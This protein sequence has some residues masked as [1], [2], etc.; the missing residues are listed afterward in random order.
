MRW[1]GRQDVEALVALGPQEVPAPLQMPDQRMRL[2]LGRDADAADT[3]VDRIGEREIDDPGLAAE[4][5][6]RLGAVSR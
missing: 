4:I 1:R 3:A 6:R 2:V 5:D